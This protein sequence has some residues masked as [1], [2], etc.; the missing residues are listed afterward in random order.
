MF[1]N[2]YFLVEGYSRS[3]QRSS[4][5]QDVK[6]KGLLLLYLQVI[7]AENDF[8]WGWKERLDVCVHVLPVDVIGGAVDEVFGVY[9]VVI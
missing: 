5:N 4:F 3:P 7:A 9:F 1:I 2:E 8:S 6:L